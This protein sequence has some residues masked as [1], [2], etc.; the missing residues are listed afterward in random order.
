MAKQLLFDE[1]AR[2]HLEAGVDR[3]AEASFPAGASPSC[4]PDPPR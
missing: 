1:G 3:L 2:A 4:G